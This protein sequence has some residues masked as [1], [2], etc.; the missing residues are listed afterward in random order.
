MT[1]K[2]LTYVRNFPFVA[3]LHKGAI[4]RIQPTAVR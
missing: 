3:A 4:A 2:L 1:T